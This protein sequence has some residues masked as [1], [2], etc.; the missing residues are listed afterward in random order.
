MKQPNIK[1]S[2]SGPLQFSGLA[3]GAGVSCSFLVT[4]VPGGPSIFLFFILKVIQIK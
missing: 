2:A 4:I 1:F 3:D